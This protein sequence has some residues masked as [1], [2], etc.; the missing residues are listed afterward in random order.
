MTCT[1]SNKLTT[2]LFCP[3]VKLKINFMKC[4]N[5]AQYQLPNY[6][7]NS[8]YLV[9]LGM[10]WQDKSNHFDNK[11]VGGRGCLFFQEFVIE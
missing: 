6:V 11:G 7:I 3:S 8:F 1:P 2:G 4:G 10:L 5:S 9:Q